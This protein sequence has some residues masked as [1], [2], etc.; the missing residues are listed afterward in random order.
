MVGVAQAVEHP[1]GI[2]E[3]W[4]QAPP[5][6]LFSCVIPKLAQ[7]VARA[8]RYHAENSARGKHATNL[9]GTA[10]HRQPKD[11]RR[12]GPSRSIGQRGQDREV[13]VKLHPAEPADPQRQH[14]PLVLEY[15][16]LAL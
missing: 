16:E 8:N 11:L 15:A 4:D 13:N 9:D 14:R 5:P 10:G 12:I 1:A 6:T 7:R 2:R 3:M